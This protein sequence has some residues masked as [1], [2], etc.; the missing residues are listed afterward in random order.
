MQCKATH[1][2]YRQTGYFSKIILD[3]LEG[4]ETLRPFYS[5]QPS[6]GGIES[7]I[8]SRQQFSGNRKILVTTLKEQYSSVET[9]AAVQNNIEKL[10]GNNCFT[11]TTAHQPAIFTGTLYFL[12]KILHTIKLAGFL[13]ESLPQYQF[14]PVFYM[15]SEDAD[16][17][18][19]GH[20]YL[21]QEKLVWDTKQS[22]AVG[23]MN[24]KG[25]EK[26]LSRIE[27]EFSVLPFGTELVK[28]LKDCYLTGP[29]IQTGTFKFVH[30]LMG[31]YGLVTLIP[32]S[33]NFKKAMLPLFEDD[34]FH[35]TPSI[36]VEET[37]RDLARNYKVQ[38][39]PRE[40]NLFYLKDSL[41][42]RIEKKAAVFSVADKRSPGAP[43]L[44]FTEKQMRDELE[45]Y[46]ER[47]SPN[48]ILRGLF[49]EIILP[50]IAFIGGGGE[51]AYWLELKNLFE[52]Y[53]VPYPLLI[54]RNSFLII[55]KRWSEKMKK[56]DLSIT[57]IWI[58]EEE[59]LNE[60]VKKQSQHQVSLDRELKQAQDFYEKISTSAS[61]ID[62]TLSQ[63]VEALKVKALKALGELEKKLLKAEKRKFEDQRRQIHEIKSALFPL[64]E[65]QE[66]IENLIPYYAVWG[67]QFIEV[68]C[69]NSLALEQK[70]V[71]LS[72]DE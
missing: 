36:L 2:T 67:R 65:L 55:A 21:D 10:L 43:G 20:I 56:L 59:L 39:H 35:Q 48:V 6:L 7:A 16:L 15:G 71:V 23:R 60:L 42:G 34:L 28:L 14:V 33:A 45:Q 61:Q 68:L 53:K 49:Q 52:H 22:G 47:F 46:P 8:R 37:I 51:L 41:R 3:Y 1:L 72:E 50:N 19:L 11:V 27:G 9:G 12:Y 25:L 66:R 69:K 4:S 64:G 18:E 40:I 30:A 58:P 38:A 5:H 13:A 44:T 54:L 63:H 26:I 32:D 17:E 70:F 24:P 57:D 29:D 31:Q 62:P